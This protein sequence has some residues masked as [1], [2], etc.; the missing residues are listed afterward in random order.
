MA[1][2]QI[3]FGTLESLGLMYLTGTQNI[4]TLVFWRL[5]K[6]EFPLLATIAGVIFS[7]SATG[8]GIERLSNSVHG[9]CHFRWA[10]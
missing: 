9:L 3:G 10:R 2:P 8:A 5:H 1:W 4:Y 7:I 6:H